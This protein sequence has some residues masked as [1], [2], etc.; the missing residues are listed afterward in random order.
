MKRNR[1]TGENSGG[2]GGDFLK[3]SLDYFREPDK[4]LY[5][6]VACTVVF[7][8]VGFWDILNHE[9]WRDELQAWLIAR[10]S[11][12]IGDL[13]KNLKYEGHQ[14]LWHLGLYFITRFT[15]NPFFMQVFHI[16]I[17]GGVVFLFV[18]YSPF[19]GFL[20]LLFIFGYY[21]LYEYATISRNYSIGVLFIF[22]ALALYRWECPSK[23]SDLRYHIYKYVSI[24]IA[25]FLAGHTNIYGLLL[26]LCLTGYFILD[27]FFDKSRRRELAGKKAV[28]GV[29]L[30][31]ILAG[32]ITSV[33][34]VIPPP[35]GGYAAKWYDSW[36]GERAAEVSGVFYK[37]MVPIPLHQLHYWDTNI[38]TSETLAIWLSVGLL[39]LCILMFIGRPLELLLYLGGTIGMLV[40]MYIK[41][42]GYLRHHGHLFL[43]L[44]T[45]LWLAKSKGGGSKTG[46]GQSTTKRAFQGRGL[47]AVN[48]V[49]LTLLLAVNAYAG[50]LCSYLDGKYVFSC[51]EEAAKYIKE[52][53]LNQRPMAGHRDYAIITVAGFLEKSIYYPRSEKMGT[54]IIWNNKRGPIG[55]KMGLERTEEYFKEEWHNTVLIL[56]FRPK[57]RRHRGLRL[58][59]KFENCVVPNEEY[60]ICE[61][62]KESQDVLPQEK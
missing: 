4:I 27:S 34:Q 32:V 48:A 47:A 56:N 55:T 31:I 41:Y 26:V 14:G 60:Y 38:V 6:S 17:G 8:F 1:E 29:T 57:R 7:L 13:F 49:V 52:N 5:F 45:A 58:I 50:I 28:L 53:G 22:A 37:A 19:N 40:F 9:M 21:P 23:Y 15:H 43:L 18:R 25:L 39:A 2:S 62:V 35:D 3:F 42:I 10:E 44:L 59:E 24:G 51:G 11:V 30:L 46:V 12:S 20:K 16:L 33:I 61:P 36:D 54:Y